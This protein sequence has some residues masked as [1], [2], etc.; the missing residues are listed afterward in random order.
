MTPKRIQQ[1]KPKGGTH[2]KTPPQ[3]SSGSTDKDMPAFCLKY[4]VDGFCIS[5]CTPKE[6]AAF[7]DTLRKL[8]K[9][10]WQQ[11]KQTQHHGLGSEKISREAILLPIPLAITEDV[12]EFIAFRFY[13]KAPMVGFRDGRIF[14]VVWVDRSYKVYKH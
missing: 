5:D 2:V 3:V 14:H 4:I 10:P 7:A 9:L 12:D 6:K 8:G 1:L 13:D 11:L